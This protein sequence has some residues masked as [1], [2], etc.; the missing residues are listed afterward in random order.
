MFLLG[1]HATFGQ[2]PPSA[3]YSIIAVRRPSLA[4]VQATNLPAPPLP[5]TRISYFSRLGM[6]VPPLNK[7]PGFTVRRGMQAAM[8]RRKFLQ[9]LPAKFQSDV[10]VPRSPG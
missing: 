9:K 4:R 6:V 1:K 2:A 7:N 5:M 8:E 10:F 3:P